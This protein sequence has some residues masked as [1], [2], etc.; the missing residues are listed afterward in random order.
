MLLATNLNAQKIVPA[1]YEKPEFLAK[2]EPTLCEQYERE[3]TDITIGANSSSNTNAATLG[4]TTV[5]GQK[6]KINGK[7]YL[8]VSMT[9]QYSILEFGPGAEI[10]I[11]PNKMMYANRSKLYACTNM[12]RGIYVKGHSRLNLYSCDIEDAQYAVSAEKKSFLTLV[13]NDF[14]R[15]YVGIRNISTGSG[16]SSLNFNYFFSNTFTCSDPLNEGYSSQIPTPGEVS[17]AGMLLNDCVASIGIF[18]FPANQF[19]RMGFG[20]HA[21]NSVVV[22]QKCIFSDM[23]GIEEDAFSATGIYTEGGTL[24]VRGVFVPQTGQY[25]GTSTFADCGYNGILAVGSNL[26]IANKNTFTGEQEYGIQSVYNIN[27]EQ[28]R[29]ALNEFY[30]SEGNVA[31]IWLER[32]AASG[33]DAHNVI[34]RNYIEING[35][36]DGKYGIY[37]SGPV[38]AGDRMEIT[39]NLIDVASTAN[40]IIPIHVNAGLGDRFRILNDT[41]NFNSVNY[42][43]YR[44]GISMEHAYFSYVGHLISENIIT[45]SGTHNPGQCAIHVDNARN[46]T[47]CS[48]IM[49]HTFHGIHLLGSLDPCRVQNNDINAHAFGLHITESPVGG[50]PAIGTQLRHGNTWSTSSS[51]Y[52]EWAAACQ[53]D[54]M[55]MEFLVNPALSRFIVESTGLDK[56]PTL[57]NPD[58]DWFFYIPGSTNYCAPADTIIDDLSFLQEE[59][60]TGNVGDYTETSLDDWEMEYALML[61]LRDNPAMLGNMNALSFYNTNSTT[62]SAGALSYSLQGLRQAM[63]P[64]SGEQEVIDEIHEDLGLLI[65]TLIGLENGY[66]TALDTTTGSIDTNFLNTKQSLFESLFDLMEEEQNWKDA[67]ATSREADL[68]DLKDFNDTITVTYIHEQNYKALN[69]YLIKL[70]LGTATTMDYEDMV[71]IATLQSPDT[72]GSAVSLARNLLPLCH[73][74]AYFTEEEGPSE[75]L[76]VFRPGVVE[77]APDE[78]TVYPNP[79]DGNLFIRLPKGVAGNIDI[80]NADGKTMYA[81]EIGEPTGQTLHIDTKGWTAGVYFC[82]IYNNSTHPL[83]RRFSFVV[84]H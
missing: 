75:H 16:T 2:N 41:I 51:D 11:Q 74:T 52:T 3:E 5:S 64:D 77:S 12:W 34:D 69:N 80:R 25:L 27:S 40:Y 65:D 62:T 55:E 54:E 78:L 8:D 76:E 71:D 22:V 70:A 38:G 24:T 42:D 58:E 28:I 72:S 4:Y 14:N 68:E 29:I 49:D 37:A 63:M 67:L 35:S 45:G 83:N 26:D 79:A 30:L 84:T 19:Y 43:Y 15:N 81:F 18:N 50:V 48:N 59:T 66:T 31:G 73:R 82:S 36:E 57:I 20:I 9:F 32:S 10:I 7:L 21:T 61:T 1:C 47:I 39:N 6:V 33:N 23:I 13:A 56:L 46:V 17:Y 53:Y 60:A 44:F